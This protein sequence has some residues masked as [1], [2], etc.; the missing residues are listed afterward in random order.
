M[1]LPKPDRMWEPVLDATL[2]GFA[3]RLAEAVCGSTVTA[4]LG[5]LA[6]AGAPVSS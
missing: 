1:A 4:G 5:S 3:D 6:V 2:R